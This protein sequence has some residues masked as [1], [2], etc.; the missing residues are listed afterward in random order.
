MNK[1]RRI[2]LRTETFERI[3][4]RKTSKTINH[5]DLN[6]GVCK[7]KISRTDAEGEQIILEAQI[8]GSIEIKE[9]NEEVRFVCR[10][11]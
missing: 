8:L 11:N 3:S 5:Q 1:K 4:L 2:I 9:T 6:L 10:K 7:I